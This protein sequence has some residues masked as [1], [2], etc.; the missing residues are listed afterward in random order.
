MCIVRF[1]HMKEKKVIIM[2]EIPA[3]EARQR[4][5]EILNE[6]SYKKKRV[7]ITKR[8]KQVAAIISIEEL[9]ALKCL[10]V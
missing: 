9:E 5:P 1:V 3:S 7:I 10:Q 4:L 6:V 8:G 2:D